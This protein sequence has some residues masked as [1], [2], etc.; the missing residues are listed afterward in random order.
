MNWRELL[1]DCLSGCNETWEDIE[2]IEFTIDKEV[3]TGKCKD[4]PFVD[5]NDERLLSDLTDDEK[6]DI[7][8]YDG[9][10]GTSCPLHFTVWTKNKIYFSRDFEGVDYVD[11]I[12]RNPGK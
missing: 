4:Y 2:A 5:E 11:S 7:D 9:D 12:N 3:H 10:Y 1:N 8:F 6:L